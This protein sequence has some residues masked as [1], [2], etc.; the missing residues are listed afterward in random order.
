M[1]LD[2]PWFKGNLI[3]HLRKISQAFRVIVY[4]LPAV[5]AVL[6]AYPS[7]VLTM[8][9]QSLLMSVVPLFKIPPIAE[10]LSK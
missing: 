7:A 1:K 10:D 6:V 5:D 8:A 9:V 2:L 3:K 4:H